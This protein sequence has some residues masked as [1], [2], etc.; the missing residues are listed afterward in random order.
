MFLGHYALGLAAKPVGRSISLGTLFVASQ[1]IDLLWPLFL[2]IGLEQV[3]VLP[4]A[5][6]LVPLDFIHY[7]W[8]HSLLMVTGWGL[9]FGL[10]HYLVKRDSGHAILLGALVVSHWLLDLL[11]HRPDLPLW[12]HGDQFGLGLWN[13][14]AIAITLEAGLFVVGA[15][16][17]WRY[18]KPTGVKGNIGLGLLVVVLGLIYIGNIVGPPP[19]NDP[20]KIGL[21]G[22]SQWLFVLLAWWVDRNR[23]PKRGAR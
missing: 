16:I 10:I 23:I 12:P 17:Y 6:E 19:P 2:L 1:F 3:A 9:A 14:A 8:S 7:P 20:V 13:S 11:V 21:V 22:I 5:T 18:T 4:G 15:F